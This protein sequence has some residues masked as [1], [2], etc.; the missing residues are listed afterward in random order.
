VVTCASYG[1]FELD[2]NRHLDLGSALR[3]DGGAEDDATQF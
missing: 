3:P 1:R 2:M